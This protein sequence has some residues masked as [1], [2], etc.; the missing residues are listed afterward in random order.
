MTCL[1]RTERPPP[2]SPRTQRS[3]RRT[4]STRPL[5][6]LAATESLVPPPVSLRV[7][8]CVCLRRKRPAHRK[9]AEIGRRPT[10]P[11]F[12]PTLGLA[13]SP[14]C[15][16]N[17]VRGAPPTPWRKR[18]GEVRTPPRGSPVRLLAS[19]RE[20]EQ[21]VARRPVPQSSSDHPG[22]SRASSRHPR[23]DPRRP[24]PQLRAQRSR[25]PRPRV[26][27]RRA[28]RLPGRGR[29][30]RRRQVDAAADPRWAVGAR[31]GSGPDRP[32]H[33]DR[34]LPRSGAP[35]HDRRDRAAPRCTAAP[36]SRRR[37]PISPRPQPPSGRATPGRTTATPRPWRA[38]NPSPPA[39]SRPASH[40]PS[41][42]S[43]FRRPWPDRGSRR[44]RV[45]RKRAWPWPPSCWP[46]ST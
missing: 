43:A 31:S 45:G 15:S 39:T 27:D 32:A 23:R 18:P 46:A 29:P 2:P 42:R 44:C 34:R 30:Q 8:K 7:G 11:T 10:E 24:P 19:L 40:P 25:R 9:L 5:G 26:P 6:R 14:T 20:V 28:G 37:K 3:Q 4:A 13:V 35:A 22:V 33:G 41:S 36:V 16:A 1:R 21:D 12:E 38:S 17:S